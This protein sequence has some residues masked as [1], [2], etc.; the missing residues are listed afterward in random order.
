MSWTL[1]R[2][3]SKQEEYE[4]KDL[5]KAIDVIKGKV[6]GWYEGGRLPHDARI[7]ITYEHS[8]ED[9][10]QSETF[11]PKTYA[12]TWVQLL[13]RMQ[14][15]ILHMDKSYP[16]SDDTDSVSIDVYVH[17]SSSFNAKFELRC[18]ELGAPIEITLI[19]GSEE[20]L[21]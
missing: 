5:Q 2:W 18:Y 8:G 21:V 13:A 3:H 6:M 20:K 12:E 14:E 9:Y 7:E 19:I 15:Y 4:M 1:T 17:M 16:H 11:E 10:T